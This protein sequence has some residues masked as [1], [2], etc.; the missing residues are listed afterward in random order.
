MLLQLEV[1]TQTGKPPTQGG[2]SKL[3]KI[4]SLSDEGRMVLRVE[5]YHPRP[6]RWRHPWRAE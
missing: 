4:H 2:N 1:V 6:L 3:C 5:D